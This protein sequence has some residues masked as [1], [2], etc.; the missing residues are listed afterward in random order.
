MSEAGVLPEPLRGRSLVHVDAGVFALHAVSW[1]PALA[2]TRP[3]FAALE[4]EELRAQTSALTLYQLVA[5]AY[6]RGDAATAERIERLLP[7]IPGL[8]V[9]PV[10][11]R[12]ARQAAQARAQ[13][14]G[15]TER[16]IQLATALSRGA[17]LFL[18]RRSALRRVAGLAIESLEAIRPE[19][20]GGS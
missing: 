4:A 1:P 16:A 14:G 17:D 8:E 19:G 2:V 15:G 10:S 13:L 18:T 12:I 3:L 7:G 9:V 6:R 11:A 20:D 5:E